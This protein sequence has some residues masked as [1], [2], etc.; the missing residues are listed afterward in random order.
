MPSMPRGW[1]GEREF[2]S[3]SGTRET[4]AA[5]LLTKAI[6]VPKAGEIPAHEKFYYLEL[7]R[8]AGWLE[9]LPGR[10]STSP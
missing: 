9:K 1:L 7:L 6:P 5:F 8:R 2:L 10:R 4:D 3:E